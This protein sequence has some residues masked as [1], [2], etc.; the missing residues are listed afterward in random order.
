ME[1]SEGPSA[2]DTGTQVSNSHGESNAGRNRRNARNRAPDPR[3]KMSMNVDQHAPRRHPR[4][5]RGTGNG[6]QT[7]GSSVPASGAR[8]PA[9]AVNGEVNAPPSRKR[10][11]RNPS[12]QPVIGNIPSTSGPENSTDNARP[13]NKPR[14]EGGSRRGTKFNASLT[15]SDSTPT[16]VSKPAE[17]YRSRQKHSQDPETLDDLTSRLIYALRTPPYPDC[18]ICFS[19]IHPAQPVWSCSPSIPVI[20]PDDAESDEQQY[21]WTSFHTK[22]IGSW[23]TKSVKDIADAWRARGEEGRRG[24]WRCPGCQAKREIIP[25]GYWCVSHSSLSAY[26]LA[27]KIPRCFCNSTP[28]PKPPRLATPHSCANPCSR[29]RESGCGHPCPLACHPGPC[30]PCQITTQLECY[31]PNKK[32]LAFRCGA[33]QGRGTKRRDLSCGSICGRM[34]GCRKHACDRICHNGDCGACAIREVVKC[35]C[36]KEEKEV[37]CGE[38]DAMT[39]SVEGEGGWIGR[40]GCLDICERC[41]LLFPSPLRL[42]LPIVNRLFDCGIHKCQRPCHPPSHQPA[43]CPHSPSNITHCPCGKRPIASSA[44]DTNSTAFPARSHCTSPIPTCTSSCGKP[45][46]N[47]G[48]PCL[49][50]CHTGPCPPCSISIVR[51]CRC[52]ATTRAVRCYELHISGSGDATKGEVAEILC[53]KPCTALRACGRHQCRRLCCPLAS[54]ASTAGKKGK[55]RVNGP[56]LG[57]GVGEEQGGL[58]ECD[59]ICGRMLACGNHKCEERDHK[60]LCPPCL[61]SSFEEV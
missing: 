52:G 9:A 11:P 8:A 44:T 4:P 29:V 32:L 31:C 58:H 2:I 36:G 12:R 39:C 22:C 33:D 13:N 51:P 56:E 60:G 37:G 46:P 3:S 53:D 6:L 19:S 47:C 55:K 57:V 41:N 20:R 45:N 34:L 40:F 23:A 18:P 21:C 5:P 25:S 38:G 54:L 10:N 17:R 50:T 30:P 59:L 15:V 7:P 48:H 49:A 35:W 42:F 16:T 27:Y 26:N 28:E 1:V 24:D 14:L 61:R 43:P